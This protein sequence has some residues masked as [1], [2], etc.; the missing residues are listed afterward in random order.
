MSHRPS[1]LDKFFSH[2]IGPYTPS[3]SD[4]GK[5]HLTSSKSD[6]LQCLPLKEEAAQVP[7]KSFDCVVLD[8]AAVV[9]FSSPSESHKTFN[10]YSKKQ[11]GPYIEN[12]LQSC[13][14]VNVVFDQYLPKCYKREER[15][16]SP[17]QS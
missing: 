15:F 9:H 3:I 11:F 13:D 1:D 12:F 14:R 17:S 7:P 5:M 4:Y 16:W 8:G 6:L 10:D 2:E